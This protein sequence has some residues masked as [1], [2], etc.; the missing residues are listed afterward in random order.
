MLPFYLLLV[1]TVLLYAACGNSQQALRHS[2]DTTG[3]FS[4]RVAFY[5]V[6]NLFDTV[7][8]PFRADEAFTPAG[9]QKWD[10]DRYAKKLGQLHRVIRGMDYPALLGLCEVENQTVLEAL[11]D[12]CQNPGGRYQIVHFESLDHRGIDV[13]LLYD[14][15]VFTVTATDTIRTAFPPVNGE[16]YTSRDILHVSGRYGGQHSLHLFINHWPSRRGGLAASEPRRLRVA[17]RLRAAVDRVLQNDPEGH[18]I[19]MGDFNDEPTNKSVR[20][21]LVASAPTEAIEPQQLYNCTFPLDAQG[22]GTYNYRGNW[23][24]LDQIIAT[25]SCLQPQAK[26]QLGP[27]QN[28]RQEWMMFVHEKYG[29]TP[30]RTYGGPNYYGGFSDH[31]PVNAKFF[32]R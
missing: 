32:N 22:L 12:S 16:T 6:E 23:N 26:L 5:N 1:V 7:D 11:A 10:E 14:P 27:A 20:E 29:A 4:P 18:L 13:A 19:L 31:L 24:Q 9:R 3:G 2:A 30:S 15:R 8:D 17:Q 28:Y 21:T 25:G